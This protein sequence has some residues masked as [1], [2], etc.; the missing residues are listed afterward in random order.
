[1]EVQDGFIVGIFNYCDHWCETC[2]FTS[3]CRLF[4]DLAR[5]DAR[6]DSNMAAVVHA[7]QRPEDPPPPPP[8]WI[9]ELIEEA[10]KQAME[11]ITAEE[12]AALTPRMAR[13][14][15]P[16]VDRAN[17]YATAVH[18]WLESID[19][20]SREN[21][22]DPIAVIAWFAPLNASKIR[23]A[24]TGLADFDGDREFPPDHEGSAK[25]ALIGIERSLA[26]WQQLVAAGRVAADVAQPRLLDLE[27]LRQR[28][29]AAIP[30][31][32]GFV[33]PGF[34]EPDAVARL[35]LEI[36]S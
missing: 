17:W 21:P 9:E 7:P 4:A 8:K 36:D 2:A 22:A 23:R 31:A 28:L 14:H 15:D 29:D 16:L 33:R 35:A 30:L 11:S 25:V 5:I 10:N 34:D 20:R 32:R 3:Y 27:W 6:D 19:R 18:D 1:M 24:L 26:A 13:P 12:L